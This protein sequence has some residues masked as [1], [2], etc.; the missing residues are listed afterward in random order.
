[1]IYSAILWGNVKVFGICNKY[2]V[3]H[4]ESFSKLFITPS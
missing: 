3:Y 4:F 2:L 1:M